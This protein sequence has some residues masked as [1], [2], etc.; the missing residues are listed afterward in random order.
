MKTAL[1][2]A[3]ALLL[4]GCAAPLA[5]MKADKSIPK[6]TY[7]LAID[8]QQ[9]Y[10]N[11]VIMAR[12]CWGGSSLFAQS[13]IDTDYFADVG[14]GEVTLYMNGPQGKLIHANVEIQ[15]ARGGT[16]LTVIAQYA[17]K[18]IDFVAWAKGGRACAKA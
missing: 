17:G 18:D 16:D 8:H 13:G 5:E 1:V 7:H 15:R 6:H 12:G 4:A 2:L 14:H 9:A 10:R 3:A 11:I